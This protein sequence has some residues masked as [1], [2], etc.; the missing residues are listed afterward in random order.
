MA[1][2]QASTSSGALAILE[3]SIFGTIASGKPKFLRFTGE[4]LSYDL[5]RE[6]STEINATAQVSDSVLTSSTAGGDIQIELNYKEYDRLIESVLRSTF[7]TFGT[8][9]VKTLTV[10]FNHSAGTITGVAGDF[11][12]L[13]AGQ[14]F[15]VKGSDATNNNDGVYRVGS[16]SGGDAVITVDT[17]TPLLAT[18]ASDAGVLISST[19][20]SNGVATVRTFS[21]EKQLG[22]ITQY[23]MHRG[24][25]FSK[26][27]LDFS[28]GKVL[29]GSFGTIG[30]DV[31]RA[32]A[33]QFPGGAP[34]ASEAFGI[35]SAVTGVGQLLVR[36]SGTTTDLLE[37]AYVSSMKVSVDGKLREQKAIG[38]LG[39]IGIGAG[40]F[41]ITG[42]A[43]IYLVT[44]AIYD[45]ALNNQLVSIAFPVKDSNGNGYGF[46]FANVKLGVPPVN[47]GAKDQDIM[48]TVPFT[49][50]APNTTTDRMISI[51]RFGDSLVA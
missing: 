46:T 25:A 18:K 22:D 9:G 43:E 48:L 40:T 28:V 45:A 1:T 37:G 19:R 39:A 17:G 26:L 23:F 14:Y 4:S 31:V 35:N 42:T 20:C 16:L 13:T 50:V 29:T 44:G 32:G 30:K 5:S 12:G 15:S 21:I 10:S 24:R 51:D 7:S 36:T 11:T 34:D 33:T 8:G 6:S 38:N 47:I 41:E 3:E 2:S 49:A 27:D